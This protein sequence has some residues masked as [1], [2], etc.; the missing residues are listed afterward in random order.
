[1][2]VFGNIV[3]YIFLAESKYSAYNFSILIH[4]LTNAIM[5]FTL[6]S[7]F[8]GSIYL[9]LSAQVASWIS[10]LLFFT[11]HRVIYR[12]N[13]IV[14]PVYLTDKDILLKGSYFYA[15]SAFRSMADQIPRLFA[16]NFLGSAFVG[17]LGLTQLIL[18]LINRIPGAINTILYPM[19]VKESGDELTKSVGIIR[20]LLLITLPIILLLE[21]FIPYF[22]SFFYGDTFS[23]VS[24][25]IQICLPFVYFGL[26][27]LILTAY[28]SSIGEFSIIF[29]T[30]LIVVITSLVS[31]YI[32]SFLSVEYA[33]II[34]ICVSFVFLTISSLFFVSKKI[35]LSDFLPGLSDLRKLLQF[36]RLFLGNKHV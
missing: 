31:L 28:F 27:G 17:N 1:L 12:K 20:A 8:E 9:A 24:F 13:T 34:A 19:L 15:S 35:L 26:P 11:I 7:L 22:I 2:S 14:Q 29:I 4:S 25:Y 10:I 6:F 32:I 3:F 21:V 18:G 36:I 16:I 23:S 5:V 30:N 33:P